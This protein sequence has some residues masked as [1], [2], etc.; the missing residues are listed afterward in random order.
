VDFTPRAVRRARTA[1]AADEGIV[2][3]ATGRESDGRRRLLVLLT[4]R[5]VL[6]T[7]LRGAAA[8]QLDP[9]TT[10]AAFDPTG[11]LLTLSGDGDEVVLRDVD[12]RAAQQLVRLL[13]ARRPRDAARDA[14]P[15]TVR[16]VG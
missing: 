9:D 4:D 7:S 3:A 5:R 10:H 16:L 15:G 11:A 13:E 14:R 2:A 6:V 8:R 1:L 12:A